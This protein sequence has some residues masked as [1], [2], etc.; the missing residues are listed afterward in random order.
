MAKD[1]LITLLDIG[2]KYVIGAETIH[3]LKSVSLTIEKGEFVALMGPSGSGKSTLMNIL[4]CLD[5]PT[6][7]TYILNGNQVSEMS[8]SELAEIRN[9]EIG[10]VFQTFNLLPRSSSLENVALPL[11]YAGVGR[12]QREDRAQKTLESVGLGNRVHHKPNELSG[13]QRQRVAV[14]RAL[15]N[16][17]SII[18]ADEPTGNLDTKTSVEIMGLLEE[19]HS[20]GNT[21]IL[22]THEEDI[23]QHA[24]RIVRM[25]DGLIENDYLNP[26]V[27]SVSP[28]L[29][30]MKNKG[31]DFEN[32]Q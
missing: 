2:R 23:A 12:A 32:I 18:L 15:V 22:V 21:I 10:F 27:K 17:P 11:V 30:D 4:G 20:K 29:A 5:T 3:A 14:A 16:N 25:R 19:I 8:D 26:N 13:G 7:G 28:R 6:K 9:K 1:P 31:S 24:H